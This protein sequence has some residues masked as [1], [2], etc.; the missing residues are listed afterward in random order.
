MACKILYKACRWQWQA[1][2]QFIVLKA[3]LLTAHGLSMPGLPCMKPPCHAVGIA[4]CRRPLV[5][6]CPATQAVQDCFKH[7]QV[8]EFKHLHHVVKLVQLTGPRLEQPELQ[9]ARKPGIMRRITSFM[10]KKGEHM[11]FPCW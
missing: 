5:D 11:E 2:Q 1:L 8:A 6:S 4:R 3:R 7:L 9:L 10:M